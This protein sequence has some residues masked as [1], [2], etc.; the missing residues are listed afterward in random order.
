[1]NLYLGK[2]AKPQMTW[3][4]LVRCMIRNEGANHLQ[5]HVTQVLNSGEVWFKI[6]VF[7]SRSAKKLARL[8]FALQ[9]QEMAL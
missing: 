3:E 9:D 5:D 7:F 1:M 2:N 4:I 6:I 8:H